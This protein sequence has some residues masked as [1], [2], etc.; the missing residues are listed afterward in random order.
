MEHENDNEIA[1]GEIWGLWDL[2][3]VA[4]NAP[5]VLFILRRIRR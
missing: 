3:V 5:E 4:F 2:Y 1:C